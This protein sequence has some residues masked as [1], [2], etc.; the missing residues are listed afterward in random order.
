MRADPAARASAAALALLAAAACMPA[1]SHRTGMALEP[2]ELSALQ[3]GRTTKRE[4][5]RALGPPQAIA[6]RGEVVALESPVAMVSAGGNCQ[7]TLGGSYRISSDAWFEAFAARRALHEDHRVY[8]WS[9]WNA[10]GVSWFLLLG[11]YA[12]CG[13]DLR[14]LWVL[15]DESTERVDD[16]VVR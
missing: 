9:S 4:L 12:T 13:N 1:F 15:V 16:L 14:E 11:V 5:F 10:S 2:G 8:Y 6:S 3:P 7:R